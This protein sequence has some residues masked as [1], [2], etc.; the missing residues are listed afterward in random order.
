[1][2]NHPQPGR[3][4]RHLVILLQLA[5]AGSVAG[6]ASA[7]P[8][9]E[10]P[11]DGG[12][13]VELDNDALGVSNRDRNFTAGAAITW[14]GS[15]TRDNWLS[16]DA[17]LGWINS[18]LGVPGGGVWARRHSIELGVALFTPDDLAASEPVTDDHPYACLPF[19]GSSRRDIGPAAGV[20]YHSTLLI[21]VLGTDLCEHAQRE[22]HDL[23][24]DPRPRGWDNQISE[25]GEL[26][27]RYSLTRM[28]PLAVRH[29]AGGHG[30]QLVWN[31]EGS[32]GFT[33]GVGAGLSGRWGW[34]ASPWWSHTPAQAEYVSLSSPGSGQRRRGRE[35]FLWGGTM[36][37]LRA[38]NALLQGQFRDSRVSLDR[39]ELRPVVGEAWLGATAAVT[40]RLRLSL[41]LR[42]RSPELRVGDQTAPMW[43]SIIVSL[44]P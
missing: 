13:R 1:M 32:A 5:L 6:F 43:G 14:S 12:W 20:A 29:S 9:G 38:Y 10:E 3:G 8:P 7:G 42:A 33:T 26:T 23:V 34:L 40:A 4:R 21:G 27:A 2:P 35:L 25:G 19:L 37:R 39:D 41:V 28:Q 15:R 22:A 16:L 17:P 36:L 18:A 44:T 11:S 24:G 31:L 30:A